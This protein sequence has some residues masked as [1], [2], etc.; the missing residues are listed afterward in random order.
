MQLHVVILIPKFVYTG[1]GNRMP[2]NGIFAL[3][4]FLTAQH[5]TNPHLC[6][7]NL[8]LVMWQFTG[9]TAIALGLCTIFF[10]CCLAFL[11]CYITFPPVCRGHCG[12]KCRPY[13]CS[14]FLIPFYSCLSTVCINSVQGSLL[15]G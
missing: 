7:S 14:F 11:M 6:E 10:H 4:A 2:L 3:L 12:H 8:A 15:L 1:D 5:Y 9:V 13:P